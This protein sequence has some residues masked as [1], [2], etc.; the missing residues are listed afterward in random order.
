[1]NRLTQWDEYGNADIISLD[2]VMPEIYAELSFSEAN[3]LTDVLNLLGTYE[4][5]GLTPA[6]IRDLHNEF[7]LQCGKYREAHVG[8]CDGCRWRME[9]ESEEVEA[10]RATRRLACQQA[11]EQLQGLREHCTDFED[12]DDPENIWANDIKALDLAIRA[13]K[14]EARR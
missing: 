5:T 6:D 11:I 14:K 1:M 3:A 8:R 9:P 2:D 12:K 4:D 7:C 10:A 13:L